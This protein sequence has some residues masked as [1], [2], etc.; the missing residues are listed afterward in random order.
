MSIDEDK[1]F[2]LETD[3]SNVAI[4]ATLNQNGKPVAFFSR[5]LNKPQKMY[6][7][8]E[9]DTMSIFEAIIHWSHFSRREFKS[10]TD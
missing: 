8:V 1:S 9:K 2:V 3:A 4:S 5:T 7:V 10:T 6:P